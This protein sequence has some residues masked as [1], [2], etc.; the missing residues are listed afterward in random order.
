MAQLETLCNQYSNEYNIKEEA[1][2]QKDHK[3]LGFQDMLAINE[4]IID[5]K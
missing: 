2:E 1:L 3:V 4:S 5:K